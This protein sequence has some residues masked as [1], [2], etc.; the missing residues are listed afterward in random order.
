METSGT[1]RS[2]QDRGRSEKAHSHNSDMHDSEESDRA[3]LPMSQPKQRGFILSGGWGGK[4]RPL[5]EFV[6][7]HKPTLPLMDNPDIES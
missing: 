2:D 6:I 4:V 7:L 5:N 3:M 1:P